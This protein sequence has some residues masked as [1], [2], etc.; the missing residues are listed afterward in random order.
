ML[1]LGKSTI[2]MAM[3]NSYVSLPKGN[4]IDISPM[5]INHSE[6]GLLLIKWIYLS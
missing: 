4:C 1:L 5:P 2:S 6:I 3:F